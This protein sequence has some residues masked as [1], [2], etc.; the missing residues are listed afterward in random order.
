MNPEIQLIQLYVWV[1]Q[2]YDKHATLKYQRWSN[3]PTLPLFT[4]Q[5]MVTIYL[6]GV[7]QGHFKQSAIH[8]YVATHWA[9]WFPHL[10]SYQA[11]NRRLNLLQEIWPVLLGEL[12]NRLGCP[13]PIAAQGCDQVL[14]S[15]PI[16]LA[17][18]SR[19]CHA[20]VARDQ[21]DQ[22]YCESKQLWYHGLK[23]P[24]LDAKQHQA[25][26]A[27]LSLCLTEASRH[28]LPIVKEQVFKPLPGNLFG[29]KAYR[30]QTTKQQLAA[31][32]TALCTPDKK[33]KGQT[34]YPIGHSGLW[35]RFVAAMRQP[36]ESFFNWL[37]EKTGIQNA[38][39]VRSSAGLLV[40]C[41]G[42]LTAAFYLLCF[43]P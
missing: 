28:D 42:K 1:C 17:V 27:P 12:W 39:K 37:N 5:E 14:D 30:D 10:P 26:P 31:C 6:F 36:I 19:S 22:S 21:A 41:Y 38:S 43:Y 20:K 40:H 7:L 29:D 15:L 35:S 25:L 8:Q 4:D 18:R 9:A 33:E 23:L 34:V 13:A 2:A 24:W 11:F 3:N 16:M 32:D